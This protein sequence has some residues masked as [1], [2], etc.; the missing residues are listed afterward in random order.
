MGTT[1]A[2]SIDNLSAKANEAQKITGFPAPGTA[3]SGGYFLGFVASG[4]AA[5]VNGG[6]GSIT[7]PSIPTSGSSHPVTNNTGVD[8]IAY[9][10]G[11]TVTVVNVDGV[12]T[13]ATSGPFYIPSGGTI[14]ITYSVAPT[15]VWA[16]AA[17]PA[18]FIQ[19]IVNGNVVK[20]PYFNA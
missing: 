7:T 2:P 5:G 17:A 19:A 6:A 20:I 15:W 3:D 4:T 11:G 13:G 18:G 8:V 16:P 10:T 9:I 1:P 12:T 14:Y